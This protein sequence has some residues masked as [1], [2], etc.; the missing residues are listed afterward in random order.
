MTS[1]DVLSAL[2]NE[3][4]L[5]LIMCLSHGERNVTELIGNCGLSQSAVSQ[6]LKKLRQA[7]LVQTYKEGKEINYRLT[8][9]NVS[10]LSQQLLTFIQ[11][12]SI[13]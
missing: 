1:Q 5:K 13:L 9:R 7:G 10:E 6:H 4:R 3:V 11:E 8:D 2:S 12:V